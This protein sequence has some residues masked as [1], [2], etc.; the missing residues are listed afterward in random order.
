MSARNWT[1]KDLESYLKNLKRNDANP[2]NI[3]PAPKLE[4]HTGNE[5]L[6]A[7]KDKTRNAV[8]YVIRVTSY[9]RRLLDT[10]NL[11]EKYHIDALRY[12]GIIHSDAADQALI[13]TRQ[14]KVKRADEEKTVIEIE[15]EAKL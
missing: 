1:K 15:S 12:A 3:L 8:R 2:D 6:E 14:I 9:R 11:C 13:E 7:H 10:D 5:S 4:R